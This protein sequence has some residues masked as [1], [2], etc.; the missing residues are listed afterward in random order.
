[1]THKLRHKIVTS[2]LT[3]NN[4]SN[5]YLCCCSVAQSCL[6]LCDPVDCSPPDSSVH[7]IS[8]ARIMEWVAIS[9]SRGSSQPRDRTQFSCIAGRFF[10]SWT[11]RRLFRVLWTASRS[12]QLDGITNSMDRSLIKLREMVKDREAWGAAVCGVA[13]SN[14]TE[15]LNNNGKNVPVWL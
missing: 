14:T 15:W 12:N 11:K 7:G 3:A 13:E 10:T 2:F 4:Q 5:P 9:F 1:M 6:T 8:Q